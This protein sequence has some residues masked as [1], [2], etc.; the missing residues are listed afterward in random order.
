MKQYRRRA[1]AVNYGVRVPAA[2]VA[3]AVSPNLPGGAR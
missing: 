2:V 1:T 3:P